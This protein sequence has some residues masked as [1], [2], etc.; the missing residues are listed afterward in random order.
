MPA[1]FRESGV[2]KLPAQIEGVEGDDTSAVFFVRGDVFFFETL[3]EFQAKV[4][5]RA[6]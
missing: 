3:A 5:G 2:E 6:E 1:T 4:R